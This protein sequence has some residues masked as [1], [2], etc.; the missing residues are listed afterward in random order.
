MCKI[1]CESH[2]KLNFPRI[3]FVLKSKFYF[4]FVKNAFS[5]IMSLLS[6]VL[7]ENVSLS[8]CHCQCMQLSNDNKEF[9]YLLISGVNLLLYNGI[10]KGAM[11]QFGPI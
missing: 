1:C 3:L 9:I 8:T 2:I 11:N 6:V 10:Y 4:Y 5:I 7:T